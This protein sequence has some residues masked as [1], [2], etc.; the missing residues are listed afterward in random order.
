MITRPVGA[1]AGIPNNQHPVVSGANPFRSHVR[2]PICSIFIVAIIEG[3]RAEGEEGKR[4]VHPPL[5]LC[6][7]TQYIK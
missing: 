2:C 6:A 3:K 5:D 1:K 7:S 4:F